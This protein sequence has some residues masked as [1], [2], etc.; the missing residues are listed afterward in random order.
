MLAISLFIDIFTKTLIIVGISTNIYTSYDLKV[1]K[2]IVDIQESISPCSSTKSH[3][4]TLLRH[5]SESRSEGKQE[6]Q[7]LW[8]L[9][10]SIT[11]KTQEY[12]TSLKNISIYREN[13]T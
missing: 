7:G 2:T 1:H 3:F 8:C 4:Q 11:R 9:D 10:S 13:W 12:F 5:K 6:T